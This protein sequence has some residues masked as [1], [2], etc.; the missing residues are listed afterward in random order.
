MVAGIELS[1]VSAL[2]RPGGSVLFSARSTTSA[3]IVGLLVGSR[4]DDQ[5]DWAPAIDLARVELVAI[6][7]VKIPIWQDLVHDDGAAGWR[8][9]GSVACGKTIAVCIRNDARE[10]R[11]LR[12]VLLVEGLGVTGSSSPRPRRLRN[13]AH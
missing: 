4:R 12:A 7:G 6:H 9:F 8:L 13:S 10:S 5:D 2:V 11:E 1:P 3:R